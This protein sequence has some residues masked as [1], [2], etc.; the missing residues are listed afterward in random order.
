MD[1]PME[2]IFNNSYSEK[3]RLYK[4][5]QLPYTQPDTSYENI[6]LIIIINRLTPKA[7]QILAK[8]NHDSENQEVHLNRALIADSSYKSTLKFRKMSTTTTLI[9]KRC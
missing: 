5:L 8:C 7:E 6:L 9:S 2:Y 4:M 1:R 3:R